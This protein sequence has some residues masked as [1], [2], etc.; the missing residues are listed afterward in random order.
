ME[1][2]MFT[3]KL[4]SQESKKLRIPCRI[5]PKVPLNQAK[6]HTTTLCNLGIKN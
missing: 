1:H 6:D 4:I 3:C 5:L 2:W